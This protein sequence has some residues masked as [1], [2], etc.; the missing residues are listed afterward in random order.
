MVQYCHQRVQKRRA[1]A[2]HASVI[3]ARRLP[4]CQSRTA[5]HAGSRTDS[6]GSRMG[7]RPGKRRL[8]PSATAQLPPISAGRSRTALVTPDR[9]ASPPMEA[10][11]AIRNAAARRWRPG[12]TGAHSLGL[13]SRA[14]GH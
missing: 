7:S 14:C 2:E 4:S 10:A 5:D 11:S 8:S 1:A 13:I 6:N 9:L 12:V 3:A